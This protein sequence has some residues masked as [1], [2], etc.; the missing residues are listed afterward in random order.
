M[1]V[2]FLCHVRIYSR[3]LSI[4]LMEILLFGEYL[5]VSPC[6]LTCHVCLFII[7]NG[8]TF[9]VYFLCRSPCMY[10]RCTV[11]VFIFV[12]FLFLVAFLQFKSI[13]YL[14][15]KSWS[16]DFLLQV[17]MYHCLSSCNCFGCTCTYVLERTHSF[18]MTSNSC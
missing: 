10:D 15:L 5:C 3:C 17:D 9:L 16:V 4:I 14:M 12:G 18:H 1:C 6:T 11:I 2:L 13:K 7:L 8:N